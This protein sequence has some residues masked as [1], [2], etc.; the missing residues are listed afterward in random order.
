MWKPRNSQHIHIHIHSDL[1]WHLRIYT[2]KVH[3]YTYMYTYLQHHLHHHHPHHRGGGLYRPITILLLLQLLQPLPPP[4]PQGG[5]G[6]LY[7]HRPITI[8]LLLQQQ[9]LPPPSTTTTPAT[10]GGGY[11]G[12]GGG[13]FGNP[14]SL[15]YICSRF[16]VPP[17][18]PP[19]MVMVITHQPPSPCGMGGPWEG[20]G[21]SQPPTN[22]N[23]TGRIRLKKVD[24]R[25]D[26][27]VC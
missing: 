27:H 22:S 21:V 1:P 11:H 17:P 23:V 26:K 8:V 9:P 6:V 25:Q 7:R 2:R 10:G 15:I 5:V 3:A 13:G 24:F 20:A 19:A 16:R 14:G 12:R 4:P 18:T